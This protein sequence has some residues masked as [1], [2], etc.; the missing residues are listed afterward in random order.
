M[1]G[2]LN[3]FQAMMLRW[4]ELHPYVAVHM[5][6]IAHPLDAA[7]LKAHIAQRLEAAGLTGLSLDHRRKRFEFLG[8]PAAVELTLLPGGDD[9]PAAAKTEIE[10]Q[11]NCPFPREGAF[12]PFRFFAIDG[13]TTFQFGLAYDHFIAGGDSIAV[14]IERLCDDYLGGETRSIVPW[15]PRAKIGWRGASTRSLNGECTTPIGRRLRDSVTA[16]RAL[17]AL[18][19]RGLRAS[20]R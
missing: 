17:P 18:L 7:R 1:R 16:L 5:V 6:S 11:L 4:R 9:P 20:L 10:R 13:R 8:G 14:L 19:L 12:T 3:L 2:K 15:T